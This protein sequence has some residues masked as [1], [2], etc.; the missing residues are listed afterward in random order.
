VCSELPELATI[1]RP[2]AAR[3]DKVYVDFLQNGRGKLI[4]APLCVRPR[5][6]APVSM[7]LAWRDVTAR[8]APERFDIRT[9]VPRL[10]SRGDPLRGV[11]GPRLDAVRLLDGLARRVERRTRAG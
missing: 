1:T 7:P 4:A 9:A 10:A 5:A 3:G 8:L 11:L 2:V 6:G